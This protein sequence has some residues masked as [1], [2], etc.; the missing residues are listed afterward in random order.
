MLQMWRRDQTLRHDVVLAVTVLRRHL[1][2]VFVALASLLGAI[3]LAL[4]FAHL[5]TD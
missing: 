1:A 4:A 2:T 3:I 5:V